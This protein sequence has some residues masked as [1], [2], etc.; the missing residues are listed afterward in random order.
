MPKRQ[1][2][3]VQSIRETIDSLSIPEPNSGCWIWLGALANKTHKYGRLCAHGV[4]DSA[5][6]LS[7]VEYKGPIPAGLEIDHLCRNKT[8]VNPDHLEAVTHAENTRRALE[9]PE[10]GYG[11]AMTEDNL[12]WVNR[13]H[14]LERRCK[15][16]HRTRMQKYGA[17]W[18][19]EARREQRRLAKA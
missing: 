1:L 10:C 12:I 17:E 5:H 4:N 6:R 3:S 18:R 19:N 13:G 16:C 7:Y 14:R 11:H 15:A 2:T 9:R 8:C